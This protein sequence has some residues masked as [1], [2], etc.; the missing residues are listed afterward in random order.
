MAIRR[1]LPILLVSILTLGCGIIPVSPPPSA[2]PQPSPIPTPAPTATPTP[3]AGWGLRE[4][5]DPARP[6]LLTRGAD[7]FALDPAWSAQQVE[8]VFKWWGLAKPI[9]DYQRLE[10]TGGAYTGLTRT[11][12]AQAV[13]ALIQAI[14]HLTPMPMMV[15]GLSHTDDYPSRAVELLGTDGQRLLLLSSSTANPDAAPWNLLYNGKFYVQL[16]GGIGRALNG[17]FGQAGGFPAASFHPGGQKPN[18]I[19]FASSGW[20]NQ[21][22]AGFDGLLPIADSFRYVFDPKLQRLRGTIVGRS[23]ILGIGNM[24][25]GTVTGLSSVNVG[26]EACAIDPIQTDDVAGAAWTFSCPLGPKTPTAPRALPISVALSTDAG[27]PLTTTGSLIDPWAGA[28]V[29][30]DL[31]ANDFIRQALAADPDARDILSDHAIALVLFESSLDDKAGFAQGWLQGDVVLLGRTHGPTDIRYTMTTPFRI[32]NGKLTFW[33][34]SR[35]KLDALL[36]DAL[37]QALVTRARAARPEV[38]LSLWYAEMDPARITDRVLLNEMPTLRGISLPACANA[39]GVK[40]LPAADQP[41]RGFSLDSDWSGRGLEFALVGSQVV[42]ASLQLDAR[43][44]ERAALVSVL[45]PKELRSDTATP[46]SRITTMRFRADDAQIWLSL[47][48]TLTETQRAQADALASALTM[49]IARDK[50][51]FWTI[52]HAW[53]AV[54]ADGQLSLTACGK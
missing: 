40:D 14:N 32:Q 12:P 38:V 25:I 18:T 49:P 4:L 44:T 19:V 39:T 26:G 8:Y 54:G 35:G 3:G 31:S 27:V 45:T 43:D 9:F 53:L 13:Q 2:S 34:L 48:K 36:K 47:D 22:A 33:R 51:D 28:G 11:V 42:V 24:V 46:F 21:V 7:G 6:A 29:L 30:P 16:D 20:P 1:S 52:Q 5:G 10:L 50:A 41:L 23:S 17:L 37:G 15:D